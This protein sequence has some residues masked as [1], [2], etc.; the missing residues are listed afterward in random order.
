M[1]KQIQVKITVT[2]EELEQIKQIA[3]RLGNKPAT[4]AKQ[5]LM[6]KVRNY[7]LFEV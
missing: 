1:T 3:S 6:E 5:L 4:I 2:E 7:I